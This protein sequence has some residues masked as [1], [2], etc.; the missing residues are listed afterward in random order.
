MKT[1]VLSEFESTRFS[2]LAVRDIEISRQ[3]YMQMVAGV[4]NSERQTLRTNLKT[5]TREDIKW[6]VSPTRR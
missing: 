3:V 6:I 5:V 1:E 4:R 2:V